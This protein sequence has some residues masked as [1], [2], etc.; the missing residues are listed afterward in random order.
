MR[1]NALSQAN[2][3]AEQGEWVEV[4]KICTQYLNN[5]SD[6]S[7]ELLYPKEVIEL[8]LLKIN[9][10]INAI[11]FCVLCSHYDKNSKR[12]FWREEC[13]N[14]VN[15]LCESIRDLKMNIMVDAD[16]AG[17]AKKIIENC[18]EKVDYMA[19][20][21]FFLLMDDMINAIAS[22]ANN[23]SDLNNWCAYHDGYNC[24]LSIITGAFKTLENDCRELG[25]LL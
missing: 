3:L 21:H 17:E 12:F 5:V 14:I 15:M 13:T 25:G 11:N 22:D 23:T 9:S 2:T 8:T 24:L 10:I 7:W 19:Q 20:Q 1:K 16:G 18:Y 6:D 4:H